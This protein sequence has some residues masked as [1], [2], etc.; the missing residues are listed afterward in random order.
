MGIKKIKIKII[1]FIGMLLILAGIIG[2]SSIVYILS[3][4]DWN[5]SL[6]GMI[7]GMCAFELTFAFGMIMF[8]CPDFFLGLKLEP[9]GFITDIDK[10]DKI[11]K[12]IVKR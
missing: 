8:I 1:R 11:N 4:S 12:N 2:F 7:A 3:S 5:I 9:P 6:G 10:S